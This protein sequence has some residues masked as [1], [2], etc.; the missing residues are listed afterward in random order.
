M[1]QL[2]LRFRSIGSTQSDPNLGAK[3][4]SCSFA[5]PK[6]EAVHQVTERAHS[7]QEVAACPGRGSRARAVC[8]GTE[9]TASTTGTQQK[10]LGR[11]SCGRCA[12]KR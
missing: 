6:D 2:R 8:A 3:M 10:R 1:S 12:W 4:G 11:R 9:R 7:V 5:D